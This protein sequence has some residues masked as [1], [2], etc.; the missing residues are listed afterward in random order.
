MWFSFS[1]DSSG[2]WFSVLQIWSGAAN[3]SD[4]PWVTG[5][6]RNSKC[7]PSFTPGQVTKVMCTEAGLLRASRGDISWN[8][9]ARD[10]LGL[11]HNWCFLWGPV[12]QISCKN[13]HKS[14]CCDFGRGESQNY[15][16][17]SL[18]SQLSPWARFQWF[19]PEWIFMKKMWARLY[20]SQELSIFNARNNDKY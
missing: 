18:V 16:L 11:Y 17:A 12:R 7:R 6:E 3:Y 14:P 5:P 20:A 10:T 8:S 19:L 1:S 2:I 4:I 9:L 13:V 15:W